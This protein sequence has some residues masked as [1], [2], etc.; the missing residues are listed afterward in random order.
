MENQG[1]ICD[2]AQCVHNVNCEK[3]DLACIQVTEHA[4]AGEQKVD[5]PHFCK[6]YQ[7]KHCS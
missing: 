5:T 4:A 7:C 1:V 6:N 2:V 3:C